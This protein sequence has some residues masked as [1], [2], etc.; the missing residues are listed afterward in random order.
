MG[1][2]WQIHY[3]S[4]HWNQRWLNDALDIMHMRNSSSLL[5]SPRYMTFPEVTPGSCLCFPPFYVCHSRQRVILT[6]FH[7]RHPRSRAKL[8]LRDLNLNAQQAR[9]NSWTST[10]SPSSPYGITQ[11]KHFPSYLLI[12]LARQ[13]KSINNSLKAMFCTTVIK[14]LVI[15][16]H[17]ASVQYINTHFLSV[18]SICC[19]AISLFKVIILSWS[20]C[21]V[22]VIIG[23]CLLYSKLQLK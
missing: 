13:L 7:P 15:K 21:S 3:S 2:R 16:P 5:L 10:T 8:C 6:H 4:H 17:T 19:C 14:I 18:T 1:D 11:L 9:M 23:L 22:L 12:L 20:H